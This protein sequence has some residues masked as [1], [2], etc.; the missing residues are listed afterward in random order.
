MAAVLH[1]VLVPILSNTAAAAAGGGGRVRC[2][3]PQR[4]RVSP[5][6]IAEITEAPSPSIDATAV[7]VT[8][9]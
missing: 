2:R 6:G 5:V 8:Q 3:R 7:T 9:N 4:V 1:A